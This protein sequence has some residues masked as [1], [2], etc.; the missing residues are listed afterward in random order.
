MNSPISP[1]PIP[2]HG[3]DET[4]LVKVAGN[5]ATTAIDYLIKD[6]AVDT[7]S[8][9]GAPSPTRTVFQQ[10]DAVELALIGKSITDKYVVSLVDGGTVLRRR[11]G[12][13]TNFSWDIVDNNPLV[14]LGKF[15]FTEGDVVTTLGSGGSAPINVEA[16]PGDSAGKLDISW[17]NP[18]DTGTG[19]PLIT[20]YAIQYREVG[21][22]PYFETVLGTSAATEHTITLLPQT[23]YQVKVAIIT[24]QNNIGVYS[25][26]KTGTTA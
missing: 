5:M 6:Q 25:D 24:G 17:N 15:E 7:F 11:E 14:A 12:F 1:T 2:E 26:A 20:G 4:I 19:Q 21:G 13:I 23:E 3:A 16:S 18:T 22:S 9:S 8:G 10:I